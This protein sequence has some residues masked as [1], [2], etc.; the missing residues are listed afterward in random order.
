[1]SMTPASRKY[2]ARSPR[3]ANRF[4]EKTMN[5]SVV[6]AK[7]AGTLS[8]AKAKSVAS[9]TINTKNNGVMR[10]L[11]FSRTKNRSP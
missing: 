3:M 1:M 10:N 7:I 4:D 8:K 9:I 5:G 2:S 6:K 11:P